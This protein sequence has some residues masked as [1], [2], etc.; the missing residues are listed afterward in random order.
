MSKFEYKITTKKKKDKKKIG[1]YR[2]PS[3]LTGRDINKFLCQNKT[4]Y[5]FISSP[6]MKSQS[7]TLANGQKRAFMYQAQKETFS[8]QCETFLMKNS[9]GNLI[10]VLHN[11]FKNGTLYPSLLENFVFD[12]NTTINGKTYIKD[13]FYKRIE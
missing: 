3:K 11:F 1:Q 7:F 12:Q 4:S 9:T 5:N 13:K 6:Y 2:Y 10:V 8:L